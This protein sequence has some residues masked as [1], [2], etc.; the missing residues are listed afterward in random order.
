M[1]IFTVDIAVISKNDTDNFVFHFLG[2]VPLFACY[3]MPATAS[4]IVSQLSMVRMSS[5]S[6]LMK[7]THCYYVRKTH[8]VARRP[9]FGID[10]D[11]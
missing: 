4:F 8:S 9:Y 11:F 6:S 10:Y 3:K 2:I 7:D 5:S 1:L